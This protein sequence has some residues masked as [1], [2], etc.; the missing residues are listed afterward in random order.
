VT[1]RGLRVRR[2]ARDNPGVPNRKEAQLL[3]DLLA[4]PPYDTEE[5]H[6]RIAGTDR[7]AFRNELVERSGQPGG[8]LGEITL[9]LREIGVGDA[10][11]RL[12]ARLLDPHRPAAQ[13][14]A[15][16][17]LLGTLSLDRLE[18][19]MEGLEREDGL[20]LLRGVEELVAER[21]AAEAAKPAHKHDDL[22]FPRKPIAAACRMKVTLRGVRPPVWR[23]IEVGTRSTFEQLHD[24]LQIA[25]G[26]TNSHLHLFDIRGL[27]IGPADPEWPEVKN[28]KRIRLSELLVGG[29]RKIDYQYD[30]GDDWMHDL[31]VEELFEPE[32]KSLLPR[33][34]AGRRAC[35]P[36]DAGGPLGYADKLAARGKGGEE[37][38][39]AED[40]DPEAF[41]R[42]AVNE[43]LSALRRP[44]STRRK[45]RSPAR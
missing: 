22:A 16:C 32:A 24:V 7:D 13:R 8:P 30:L 37:E 17:F 40:F 20:Q 23:R 6:R 34:T 38:W 3:D 21:R 1:G 33:C 28:E 41:D 29:I 5:F 44:P 12:S 14:V 18:V 27:K 10:A 25:M 11:S 19:L 15:A 45:R 42:D 9:M 31:V 39:L 2:R 4:R 26:W 36:E 35:P 43:V